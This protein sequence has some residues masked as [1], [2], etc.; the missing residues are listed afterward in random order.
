MRT[1]WASGCLNSMGGIA[2]IEPRVTVK[3][4]QTVHE[5]I[6]RS[7]GEAFGERFRQDEDLARWTS[8]RIGGPAEFYVAAERTDDL[9]LAV[10]MA[11][12]NRLPWVILGGG[13]N[14]LVN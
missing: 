12:A 7:F 14:V 3:R 1:G 9:V 13:S 10:R 8:A 11:H 5:A 2:L 4:N 6:L